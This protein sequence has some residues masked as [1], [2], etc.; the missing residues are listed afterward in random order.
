MIVYKYCQV[1]INSL[2]ILMALYRLRIREYYNRNW[3]PIN[4]RILYKL[5]SLCYIS[6][7]DSAPDYLCSCLELYNHSSTLRSLSDA[8]V[9]PSLTPGCLHPIV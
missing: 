7:N 4:K 1:T 9:L 2:L 5:A 6:L 8:L 3:L